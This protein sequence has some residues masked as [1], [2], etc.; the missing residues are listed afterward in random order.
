METRPIL[1]REGNPIFLSH[2]FHPYLI[3]YRQV[4]KEEAQK[5]AEEEGLLWTEA[6]AKS[7]E[8]VQE[9]FTA[10]GTSFISENSSCK[11]INNNLLLL[12]PRSWLYPLQIVVQQQQPVQL[13]PVKE[14]QV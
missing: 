13:P 9:I 10:I 7:G 2:S 1:S 8:G 14:A 4:S 3:V 6:S 5:Y 11:L 12:K